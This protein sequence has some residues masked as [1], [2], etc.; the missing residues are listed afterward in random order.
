MP[1]YEYLCNDCGT[2]YEQLVMS[3]RQVIACPK[4]T[5][6]RKTLQLS[7]FSSPAK[8]PDAGNGASASGAA[9]GC[10]PRSCGCS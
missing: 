2:R 1:I 5:S 10:T 6:E 4:C 3:N 9:C 8:S 7:V